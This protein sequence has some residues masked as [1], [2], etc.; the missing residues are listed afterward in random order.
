M[1]VLR[2]YYGSFRFLEGSLSDVFNYH[3]LSLSF[4][5]NQNAA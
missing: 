3:D 5:K 4:A 1:H 2:V